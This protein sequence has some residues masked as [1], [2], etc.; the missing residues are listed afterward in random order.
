MG[1]GERQVEKERLL[2]AAELIHEPNRVV[3][4][5]VGHK[6]APIA[7]PKANRDPL[8]LTECELVDR[9]VSVWIRIG[10]FAQE[11]ESVPYDVVGNALTQPVQT[12]RFGARS[13]PS[14]EDVLEGNGVKA[15]FL[16]H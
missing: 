15:F 1:R 12:K 4:E 7:R 9:L 14:P 16:R 10:A 8:T 5:R 13:L 2:A 11:E 3:H 6:E